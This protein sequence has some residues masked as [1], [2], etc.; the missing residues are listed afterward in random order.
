M[1][2]GTYSRHLENAVAFGMGTDDT[3]NPFG[4]GHG[5][6]HQPDEFMRIDKLVEALKIYML[7]ILELDSII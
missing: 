4:P 2:G 6:V 5:G 7:S 1:G 3:P